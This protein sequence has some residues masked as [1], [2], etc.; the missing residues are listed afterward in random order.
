[1][2]E[3]YAER[4]FKI[5][6]GLLILSFSLPDVV[7]SWTPVKSTGFARTQHKGGKG[8]PSPQVQAFRATLGL[9]P[10]EMAQTVSSTVASI[11]RVGSACRVDRAVDVWRDIPA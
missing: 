4:L 5:L 11:P 3:K 1:M 2:E 9:P 8:I 6:L 10:T 7:A